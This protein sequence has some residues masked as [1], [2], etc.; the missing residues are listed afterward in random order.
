MKKNFRYFSV[1]TIVSLSLSIFFI[2]GCQRDIK[3]PGG[4]PN[5][6]GNNEPAVNDIEMVTG[7]IRGTVIDEN[8]RPVQGAIVSSGTHTAT[9]DRYGSF[10]FSNIN[11]SKANGYVK[12]TKTGYFNGSR[13]FISKAG[14]IH[15]VRI[16]LLPKT[17]AGTFQAAAG[18][19]ITIAGGGK[20]IMPANAVM[21]AGGTAYTGPVNVAMTWIDP[22]STDLPDIIPGDLR[23]VLTGG[24]ERGLQ[25]FGMLGV[26]LTGGTGQ[27]LNIAAGKTAE[28]TFPLPV[29]LQVNA[30]ATI[31]LWHFDE[32]PGRWKQEGTAAKNGNFYIAK[33]SHFSFWNCDAP[34]PL[35]EVCMNI[36]SAGDNTP[37]NNVQV[38][39]KRPNG[40]YGY[41][42]TDSLGN[43]CGKMPK[44]EALVLQV[45]DQ[46]NNVIY[47]QNIGPFN[48]DASVGTISLTIPPVN[49]LVIT[50]TLTNCSNTNVTDGALI[51]YTGNVNTY[52]VPVTDGTFSLTVL[53]CGTDPLNFSML[54]IDYT[55]LQQGVPIAGSGTTGNVNVGTVQACGT[56]ATEFMEIMVNGVPYSYV[57]P[58]DLIMASDSTTTGI[59]DI[60]VYASRPPVANT[61]PYS[62]F[63]FT[64]DGTTG[65]KS[66]LHCRIYIGGSEIG[67]TLF[68]PP[69]VVNITSFGPPVSGFIEGNFN[70][71]VDFLGTP[72]TV[73]CT[74]KARRGY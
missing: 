27:S 26:E 66:L 14:R 11:L 51:I 1:I 25:T 8:N 15:T 55:G 45:L 46:C 74:F 30:P 50:G 18:G 62:T 59:G 37:L 35:V 52:V 65:A 31:D 58:P 21:D 19:T 5:S 17:N 56:S 16:K 53:R 23:G 68:N 28:L 67:E 33:V 32:A 12:V 13:T 34:F 2:A 38:R 29:S 39:T 41:G 54:G 9:T 42:R 63:W 60:Y 40:S 47:S 4:N 44:N 10:I 7:G 70:V 48:S 71:Q 6:P 72:K 64:S 20:M 36:V 49:S 3:D 24:Q 57:S 69:A 43:L 61:D 73:V 22:A